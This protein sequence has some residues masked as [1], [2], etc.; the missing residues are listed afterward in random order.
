VLLVPS[1]P[2]QPAEW[3]VIIN[4]AYPDAARVTVMPAFDVTW[5]GRLFGPAPF[6]AT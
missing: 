6:S 3:N 5:H 1:V 2:G 4:P